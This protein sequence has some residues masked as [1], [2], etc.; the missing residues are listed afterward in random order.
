[1]K[2]N[3]FSQLKVWQKAHE[4][5]LSVYK[6]TNKFPSKERFG[7]ISQLNRAV[8]SVPTNIVEGNSRLSRKEFL[9]FLT[10]AR[11]SLEETKYH[12]ILSRDLGYL[13]KSNYS[14]LTD[15]ANETG[16]MLNGLIV[17]VRN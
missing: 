12:L 5:T 11:G 8:A 2:E 1:M 13:D 4:L 17:N 9:Q 10:I 7:L 16:R 3:N 15:L 14:L 6:T